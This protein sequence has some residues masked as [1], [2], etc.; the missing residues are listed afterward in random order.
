MGSI[1]KFGL[2]LMAA[3]AFTVTTHVFTHCLPAP[4]SELGSCRICSML[5]AASVNG[6]QTPEPELLFLRTEQPRIH[7]PEYSIPPARLPA[8]APPG[9]H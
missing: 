4:E 5:A 6:A 2:T 3:A 1:R 7:A 8:R 9:S